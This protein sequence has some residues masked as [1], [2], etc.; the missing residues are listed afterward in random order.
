MKKLF[1]G[2]FFAIFL[3]VSLA[4]CGM[5]S[6]GSSSDNSTADLKVGYLTSPTVYGATYSINDGERTGK[7]GEDGS[8]YYTSDDDTVT[9]SIGNLI[10]GTADVADEITPLDLTD[11]FDTA[12]L[13]VQLLLAIDSYEDDTSSL[14]NV[15]SKS[16][17]RAMLYVDLNK[18][19]EKLLAQKLP[20]PTGIKY[21]PLGNIS[22][23]LNSFPPV[24]ESTALDTLNETNL[25]GVY[26]AKDNANLK[27]YCD[28][29][30]DRE[31]S[32][33]FF[34]IE[35]KVLRGGSGYNAE[36]S[37]TEIKST[38]L[39]EVSSIS[40]GIYT[41]DTK[42]FRQNIGSDAGATVEDLTAY[43]SDVADDDGA[44]TITFEAKFDDG[45]SGSVAMSRKYYINNSCDEVDLKDKTYSVQYTIHF[46]NYSNDM[47]VVSDAEPIMAI[48]GQDGCDVTVVLGDSGSQTLKGYISMETDDNN[49]TLVLYDEN[50]ELSGTANYVTMQSVFGSDTHMVAD[51]TAISSY[52]STESVPHFQYGVA[53]YTE[54]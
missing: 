33:L 13:M 21:I 25:Y 54:E 24:S 18:E 6:S 36:N 29:T 46:D 3:I 27:V 53:E 16:N 38:Y 52:D 51:I 19:V 42:A 47:E 23:L 20:T 43:I 9:F 48:T 41:I 11:T 32:G 40:D 37:S 44:E 49:R 4:G 2:F 7:T 50:T 31:Y 15:D 22:D 10:F 1:T 26:Q 28:G 12:V 8:F 45:C 30:L 5:D 39:G 34:D 17:T 14:I 35:D